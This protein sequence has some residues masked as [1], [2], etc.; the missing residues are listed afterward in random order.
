MIVPV[1]LNSSPPDSCHTTATYQTSSSI[2]AVRGACGT[3][4]QR[5][6]GIFHS[7]GISDFASK[8]SNFPFFVCVNSLLVCA[9]GKLGCEKGK[10]E[11]S[12]AEQSFASWGQRAAGW[13]WLVV[14]GGAASSGSRAAENQ[15]SPSFPLL[16]I[17]SFPLRRS[18]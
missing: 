4:D 5:V 7:V 14:A 10:K 15:I 12:H 6:G 9:H 16:Q 8:A 13:Q 3:A 1:S 2:F 17:S 11:G 18:K